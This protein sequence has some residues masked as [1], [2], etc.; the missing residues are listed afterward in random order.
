MKIEMIS[1]LRLRTAS[2]PFLAAVLAGLVGFVHALESTMIEAALSIWAW[3]VAILFSLDFFK[4]SLIRE[5]RKAL[6]RISGVAL[7]VISA[8]FMSFDMIDLGMFFT[9]VAAIVYYGKPKFL[10]VAAFPVFL[11]LVVVPQTEYAHSLISHP[12]RVIGANVSAL[13]LSAFGFYA[14]AQNTIVTISG[15]DIAI[16]AACSGIEQ[17]EAMLLMGWLIVMYMHT[18]LS[19]RI[20]HFAFILPIILFANSLRLA[21]TLG[22]SEVWG[23]VFL[24]D[25]V[26]TALGIVTVILIMFIFAAT[27]ALFSD[28][29][30][31]AA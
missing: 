3:G 14:E 2:L 10:A 22:G 5:R 4:A 17:L 20:V 7:I 27:G 6:T 12:M 21:V 25:G 26:H 18:R 31:E 19:T 13:M 9:C 16:T 11:W 30:K 8:V 29:K 24:S 28:A 23:D 1:A 15:K